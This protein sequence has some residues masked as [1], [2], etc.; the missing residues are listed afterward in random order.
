MTIKLADCTFIVVDLQEKLLP[1]IANNQDVINN[2]VWLNKVAQRLSIPSLICEQYPKGLGKTY[3]PIRESVPASVIVEKV[4]F[5]AARDIV[6]TDKL[7]ALNKNQVIICGIEA[8]VCVLQ[9]AMDLKKID[10]DVF[11][12]ADAIGSRNINDKK[13]AIKRMLQNDICVV[14]KEMV[15]FEC[16]EQAGTSLFKA[17]STEF[18]K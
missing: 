6:F 14:T 16:L 7:A 12:V 9:T 11:V 4:T 18:L 8:H 17:M 2:C 15:L 5:S 3:A 10:Y 1:T 13:F